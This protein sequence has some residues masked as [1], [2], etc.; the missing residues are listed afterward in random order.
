[1]TENPR[2]YHH[3]DLRNALLAATEELLVERGAEGFSLR[4]VAR[5]AGVSHGA[6][7]HHFPNR[8]ALLEAYAARSF[9]QLVRYVTDRVASTQ[10]TDLRGLLVAMCEGYVSF[11]LEHPARFEIMFRRDL[12]DAEG[13]EMRAAS[14]QSWVALVGV[15]DG[16]V[17]VG[18]LEPEAARIVTVQCWSLIHGFA[19]L[20]NSGWLGAQIGDVDVRELVDAMC[21]FTI[22]RDMPGPRRAPVEV[23]AAGGGERSA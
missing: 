2:R 15:V 12:F 3:G 23:A 11:A 6:P 22:W 14:Q 8:R 21:R 17:K 18:V 10:V 13:L 16:C 7:A 5:R 4:E 9:T 19:S 1:M 20:W